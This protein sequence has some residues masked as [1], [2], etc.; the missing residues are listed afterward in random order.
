MQ[1]LTGLTPEE[2]RDLAQTFAVVWEEDTRLNWEG[3]RRQRA[4]GAGPRCQLASVEE[5]LF[6]ALFYL[7]HYLI[8]ELMGALFGFDQSQANRW[9]L[10]LLPL[11]QKALHRHQA[12]PHRRIEE[13]EA[14]LADSAQDKLFLDGTDRPRRRPKDPQKQ[15]EYYSGRKKRHTLKNLILSQERTV[16][17]LSP[18]A[19]GRRTDKRLSKP[20]EAV[21]FPPESIVLTDLGFLGLELPNAK[22]AQPAKKP[23]GRPLLEAL[24]VYNRIIAGVRVKIEHVIGSIK[25]YRIVSDIFRNLKEDLGDVVMEMAT[26]L[27]NFRE[28]HRRGA[29]RVLAPIQLN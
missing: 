9:I 5:K 29:G 23:K 20:L 7:R 28:A 25:R 15:K 1:V 21:A 8:Q 11:L 12:L 3:K 24:K 4:K 26:G 13:L 19:P 16:K 27:H 18:T 14:E 6:F 10:R 2:F 22:L 17:F